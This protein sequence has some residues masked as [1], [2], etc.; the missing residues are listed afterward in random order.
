[1]GRLVLGKFSF[2]LLKIWHVMS[3]CLYW[4]FRAKAYY[5]F[6]F[7]MVNFSSVMQIYRTEKK[8]Q[9]SDEI[10]GGKSVLRMQNHG[11]ARWHLPSLQKHW[12]MQKTREKIRVMFFGLIT[13]CWFPSFMNMIFWTLI[14][15]IV[16]TSCVKYNAYFLTLKTHLGCMVS[17]KADVRRRIGKYTENQP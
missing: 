8:R 13:W 4:F 1:M 16:V 17:H 11:A 12:K 14:A 7:H 6:P 3:Q 15:V 5:F 9:K 2:F 10:R